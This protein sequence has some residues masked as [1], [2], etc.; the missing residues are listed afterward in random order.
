MHYKWCLIL[1]GKKT[2][3]TYTVVKENHKVRR[4]TNAQKKD[5]L[6]RHRVCG[7][8]RSNLIGR[9]SWRET[10]SGGQDV[11]GEA[12]DLV[13]GPPE[14][15]AKPDIVCPREME[16]ACV[17]LGGAVEDSVLEGLIV[18]LAEGARFG[19][20]PIIRGGDPSR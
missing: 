4:E 19:G 6:T 5:A 8:G 12:K 15:G 13:P 16:L 18:R 1:Q 10:C 3:I 2:T 7:G 14:G 17:A 20:V 9:H 11:F